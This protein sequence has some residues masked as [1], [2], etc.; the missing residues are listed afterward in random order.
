MKV[1][2]KRNLDRSKQG[3]VNENW[4]LFQKTLIDDLFTI[5]KLLLKTALVRGISSLS[6][7][8]KAAIKTSK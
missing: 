2:G 6:E 3:N 5:M 1:F 4:K 8:V 7:E